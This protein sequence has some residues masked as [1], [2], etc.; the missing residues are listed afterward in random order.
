MP[1][2]LFATAAAL[3]FATAAQGAETVSFKEDV[4]PILQ[5]R[6]QECHLPGGEGFEESGFDVSSYES[7]MKGTRFGAMV[8]PGDAQTSNLMVLLDGKAK[9][10][11][12]PHGKK[13]LTTCDRDLIRSWIH[14]G[15]KDN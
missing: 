11:R 5:F 8:V 4:M 13:K 7:V 6:C 2:I 9:G 12:M 14:Q 1:R 15:A 10:I 3:V